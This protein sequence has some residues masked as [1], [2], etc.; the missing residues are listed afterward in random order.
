MPVKALTFDV[1][2][3]VVD[4]RG[5]LLEQLEGFGRRK[6]IT[7]DWAKFLD[8]WK[9]AYR[10]SMDAVR[11]GSVPWINVAGIYRRK[12]EELIQTYG[13]RGLSEAEIAELNRGWQRIKPWP[14]AVAGLIRLKKKYIIATLSNGDVAGLVGLSKYG[15]LPWDCILCA[16]M[17]RRYKPDPEVYRGA[18]AWLDCRP[19]EVMMVAA[20][21]YDLA[22]AR[23]Q[24]MRTAFV[25]RPAEYGPGQTSDLVA[26]EDWE[27]I[28]RDFSELATALDI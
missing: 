27:V 18:V 5:S 26:E 16:E 1:Y 3:T 21:N 8:D 9:S 7:I 11:T 2:G 28:A 20:H 19:E 15:G 14:D 13:L 25:A 22:A 12:L 4:W 23:A 6:G 24:G 17:F 10:P